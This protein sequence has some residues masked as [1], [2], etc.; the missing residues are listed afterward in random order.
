MCQGVLS[1]LKY[2][3]QALKQT[4]A[5]ALALGEVKHTFIKN[6]I[7]VV[8]EDLDASGYN[9]SINEERN[10]GAFV[11]DAEAMNIDRLL[12]RSQSLALYKGKYGD[13]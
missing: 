10:K 2:S 5:Q 1:L 8:D 7:P 9:T 12:S 6:T 11:M 13:R 3:K 4:C